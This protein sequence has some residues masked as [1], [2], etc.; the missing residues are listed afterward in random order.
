MRQEELWKNKQREKQGKYDRAK[1][2]ALMSVPKTESEV[3]FVQEFLTITGIKR[4]HI[5]RIIM[6]RPLSQE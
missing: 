3:F 6:G 1:I 2:D 5:E 4:S